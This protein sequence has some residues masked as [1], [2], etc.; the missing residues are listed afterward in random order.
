MDKE[1]ALLIVDDLHRCDGLSAQVLAELPQ[2]TARQLVAVAD[3]EPAR[4]QG[5][6]AAGRAH[7]RAARADDGAKRARAWAATTAPPASA[8]PEAEERAFVPLYLEQL[9]ALGLAV[10]GVPHTLP[11][12]LA[13]AVMQRMQRLSLPARRMLQAAS[14][15]GNRCSREQLTS[16]AELD[17]FAG[18]ELLKSSGL[19]A[20]QDGQIEVVHPFIRDLVEASIPAEARKALHARALEAAADADAPLEVRA[21]HAY[22]AG[23]T[24]TAL[25]LLERMG[26]LASERG[27][28]DSAVLGVPA[29]P[30]PGAARAA[31]ARARPRSKTRWR[32]S[33]AS[34]A[35]RWRAAAT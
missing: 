20:E 14:V 17:D 4:A 23:E 26:D 35:T 25:M 21:H 33:A 34:S 28:A 8:P 12:R 3:R 2:H 7:D 31:R 30:R 18:F 22:G 15:L 5:R 11:R 29:L 13:D 16:L 6:P 19:L 9:R 24:L 10:D 32:A 27:D 1:R